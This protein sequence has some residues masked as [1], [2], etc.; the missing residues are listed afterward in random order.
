MC[1]CV[2]VTQYYTAECACCLSRFAASCLF[3]KIIKEIYWLAALFVHSKMVEEKENIAS[4]NADAAGQEPV[5]KKGAKKQAKAAKVMF[6]VSTWR[7]NWTDNNEPYTY[8]SNII[9]STHHRKLSRKPR[10]PQPMLPKMRPATMQPIMLPLDTASPRWYS[11][12]TSAA[13]ASS[14]SCPNWA[15]MWARVWSGCVVE[16]TRRVPRANS[17][18]LFCASRVAQCNAF[19]P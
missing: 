4:A 10:M 12:R 18:S 11:R 16:C 6:D 14:W 8:F 17:V 9:S 19:S 7:N 5:S 15:S 3:C 2:Y 13:N 1:M